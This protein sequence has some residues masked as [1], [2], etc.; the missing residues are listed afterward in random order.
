[1]IEPV[2]VPVSFDIVITTSSG[3]TLSLITNDIKS[4]VSNYVNR[5]AVGVDV[6]LTEIL[7]AIKAVNGVFDVDMNVP[8]S[9]IAIAD[10]ELARVSEEDIAIS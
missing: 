2:I 6:I 5:L 8:T 7:V 3:I 9:N 4:A 1:V 10:N